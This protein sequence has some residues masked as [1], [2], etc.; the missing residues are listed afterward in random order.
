[1]K[2][3]LL[4]L[5]FVPLFSHAQKAMQH[6]YAMSQ[7]TSPYKNSFYEEPFATEKLRKKLNISEV[8]IV[9]TNKRGRE[10]KSRKTYNSLGKTMFSQ[11]NK[12]SVNYTYENDSLEINRVNKYKKTV[13]ETKSAHANGKVTSVSNYKNGK[14]TSATTIQY[15]AQQKATESSMKIGRKTYVIQHTYGADN[16]LSK[17]VYL[18]KGKVKKEWIYECKPEGQIVASKT[19]ALS[20]FCTYQSESAD[21]SY[22]TF[23][24]SLREG[25]PYLYKQTYNKDSVLTS[26]QTYLKDSLLIWQSEKDGNMETVTA[27]KESGKLIYKQITVSDAAGNMLSREYFHGKTPRTSYKTTF[28]L[29]ADGT[30]KVQRQFH[31]GKLIRTTNYMYSFR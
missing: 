5:L 22:S 25:K 27:Y 17:T 29:N 12:W 21:G 6:Y 19:E 11:G 20:S 18:A 1:M 15:N 4:S 3:A 7:I 24:R 10:M 28:E 9:Y 2:K 16:K 14:L 31:K 8:Q 26:S 30:T 23:T 13:Y